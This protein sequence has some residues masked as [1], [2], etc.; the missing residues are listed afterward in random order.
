MVS[1]TIENAMAIIKPILMLNGLKLPEYCEAYHAIESE[2]RRRR[3]D[4]VAWVADLA[5][6]IERPKEYEPI[7]TTYK[8]YADHLA[9]NGDYVINRLYRTP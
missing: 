5:P 2:L 9:R 6:G 8:P 1:M 7:I 3:E 4:A